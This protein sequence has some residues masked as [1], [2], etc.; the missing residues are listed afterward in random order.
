MAY[1]SEVKRDCI[2]YE[3]YQDMGAS[4]DLC[5]VKGNSWEDTQ[6]CRCNDCPNYC[7]R[8]WMRHLAREIIKEG[9]EKHDQACI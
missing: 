3:E 1:N 8:D 9:E 5:T 6:G 2:F 4:T 7:S